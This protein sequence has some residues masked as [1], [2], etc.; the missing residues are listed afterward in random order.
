MSAKLVG[1]AGG[2]VFGFVLSWSELTHRSV[3]H[4]MLALREADVFLLMGSA[5]LIAAAGCHLLRVFRATSLVTTERVQWTSPT[6]EA[7]HVAGAALFGVG[8]T[9]AGTCPG[10]AAAMLGEGRLGGVP[11]VIGIMIGTAFQPRLARRH[12]ARP[13]VSHHPGA[14]GL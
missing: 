11:V 9:L 6:V 8:W 3:I 14:A 7:R 5:I 1:L 13:L 2:I 12:V 4:D 10:P